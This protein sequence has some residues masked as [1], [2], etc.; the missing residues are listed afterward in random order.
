MGLTPPV[1]HVALTGEDAARE[2]GGRSAEQW[3]CAQE[4]G[5]DG[6]VRVSGSGFGGI[7]VAAA[8]ACWCRLVA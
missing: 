8:V 5:K 6:E 3:G 7:R 4:V 1:G 2:T